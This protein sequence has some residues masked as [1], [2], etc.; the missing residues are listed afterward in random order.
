[1]K[2]YNRVCFQCKDIIVYKDKYYFNQSEKKNRV[3]RKC[4]NINA[5]RSKW[6]N[7]IT[8]T[9]MLDSPRFSGGHHSEQ[10]KIKMSEARTGSK[11]PCYGK[12][13]PENVKEAVRKSRLGVSNTLESRKKVSEKLLGRKLTLEHKQNIAKGLRKYKASHFGSPNYNKIAC[14]LF[15]QINIELGWNGQ[16]AENGGEYHIKELG[17]VVDYYEPTHNVVIEYDEPHHC[18]IKK[19]EKDKIRQ[20]EIE[21]VLN[22]KFIRIPER[23]SKNWKL[24][25]LIEDSNAK[26]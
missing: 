14:K 23:D 13:C 2:L 5:N 20:Q 22:C 4:G 10:T 15:E 18:R 19:M 26:K 24:Y 25:L 12:P 6:A 8:R 1:M 11:H 3:C 16:H 9:K 21:E 7:P 17:Y